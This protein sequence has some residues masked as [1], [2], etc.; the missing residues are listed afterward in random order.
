[1]NI[2]LQDNKIL[3][4]KQKDLSI[5]PR[6]IVDENSQGQTAIEGEITNENEIENTS[7]ES[8]NTDTSTETTSTALSEPQTTNMSIP[9]IGL[10]ALQCVVAFL[11]IVVVL[12]QSKSAS[13][14]T[15]TVVNSDN[16]SYWNQNKGRS[17]ESKLS[18]MTI[19]LGIIFFTITI[20]LSF[21]R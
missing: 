17:K 7:D 15:S 1:M 5:E 20:V 18:R 4:E 9:F 2:S 10:S 16:Q 8:T 11:L 14:I 6:G 13:S 21:I 12:Q 19:V 3:D